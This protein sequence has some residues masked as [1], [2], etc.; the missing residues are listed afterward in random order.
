MEVLS[1]VDMLT[2]RGC[3]CCEDAYW[4]VCVLVANSGFW[5]SKVDCEFVDC[6]SGFRRSRGY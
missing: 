4:L 6:G 1:L 5:R 2:V 3:G